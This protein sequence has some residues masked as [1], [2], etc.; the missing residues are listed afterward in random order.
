ML[1]TRQ[2]LPHD[3]KDDV[4]THR[5]RMDRWA[6]EDSRDAE[7]PDSPYTHRTPATSLI[8][9]T[10]VLHCVTLRIVS[11]RTPSTP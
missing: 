10:I 1:R 4:S 7:M 5:R 3:A 6:A 8:A 9:A 2:D 11:H